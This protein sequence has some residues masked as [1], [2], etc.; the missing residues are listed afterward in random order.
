MRTKESQKIL[1]V[2]SGVKCFFPVG[3]TVAY[4]SILQQP[5]KLIVL[6]SIY[7]WLECFSVKAKEIKTF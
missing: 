4:V 7:L 3:K 2:P 5:M 1:T 6:T